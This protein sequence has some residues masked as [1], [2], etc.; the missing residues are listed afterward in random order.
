MIERVKEKINSLDNFLLPYY[1]Q[2][3]FYL[4]V[5]GKNKCG[6]NSQGLI[7]KNSL[8]ISNVNMSTARYILGYYTLYS[9]Q[10]PNPKNL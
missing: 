10:I 4:C 9:T 1:V 8:G 2:E 5:G 3:K 7:E 6:I